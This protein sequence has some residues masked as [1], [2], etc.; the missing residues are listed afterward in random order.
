MDIDKGDFEV[1][2]NNG[3]ELPKL[4]KETRKAY[5]NL[6]FGYSIALMI[7]STLY[8]CLLATFCCLGQ[9]RVRFYA[10]NTAKLVEFLSTLLFVLLLI[11]DNEY[12]REGIHFT[13]TKESDLLILF[14]Y[15][16]IG[17]L[18]TFF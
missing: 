14:L 10:N 8:A 13:G 12:E 18:C 17:P 4:Y 6:L 1:K 3:D 15:Y 2:P 5:L 11:F 7:P 16:L 9:S